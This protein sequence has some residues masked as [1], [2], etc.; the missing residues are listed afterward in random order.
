MTKK[1]ITEKPMPP[2]LVALSERIEKLAVNRST[3]KLNSICKRLV[4][5]RQNLGITPEMLQVAL[6]NLENYER[7]N[8]TPVSAVYVF[9]AR[10]E[11]I[12]KLI[13]EDKKDEL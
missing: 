10:Q 7:H 5:A 13:Q 11:I 4:Q 1:K 12:N 6:D 2:A 8:T 3:E 9:H